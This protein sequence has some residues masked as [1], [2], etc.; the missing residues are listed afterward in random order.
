MVRKGIML[1]VLFIFLVMLNGCNTV[2]GAGVGIAAGAK[3]DWQGLKSMDS[4]IRDN[5]W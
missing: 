3:K 4:W 1:F 5:L 2:A